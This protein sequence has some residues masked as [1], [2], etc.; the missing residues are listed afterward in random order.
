M[1]P[2]APLDDRWMD[3]VN[4]W[5]ADPQVDDLYSKLKA[6]SSE[7]MAQFIDDEDLGS[8]EWSQIVEW[9]GNSSI[10]DIGILEW[11]V[12]NGVL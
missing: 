12:Y 3:F 7:L 6:R 8:N 4:E 11:M 10:D 1:A 9:M 5:S 2:K